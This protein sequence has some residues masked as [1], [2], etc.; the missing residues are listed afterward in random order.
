MIYVLHSRLESSCDGTDIKQRGK[1]NIHR[2]CCIIFFFHVHTCLL[3]W[4][5][6]CLKKSNDKTASCWEPSSQGISE[7]G[8][9]FSTHRA[10]FMALHHNSPPICVNW[11]RG[12]FMFYLEASKKILLKE[13]NFFWLALQRGDTSYFSKMRHHVHCSLCMTCTQ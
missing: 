11:A 2:N 12:N 13:A 3:K 6:S 7:R 9:G 4:Q 8:R 10:I 1:T 5:T